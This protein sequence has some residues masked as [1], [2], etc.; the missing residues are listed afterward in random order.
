MKLHGDPL[1][2]K[3][4][5][6]VRFVFENWDG[7]A[8]WKRRNDKILQAR[9]FVRR[10][11]ADAYL[12]A[13]TRANWKALPYDSLLP[14]LFQ[15]QTELKAVAGHNIHEENGRAQEGGTCLMIFDFLTTVTSELGTDPTGLGRWCWAKFVG[16]N[17]HVT[18][19]VSAYQPV[20]AGKRQLKA[21]YQQHRR[22]FRSKGE[23]QCPRALFRRDL[24]ASVQEWKQAGERVIVMLDANEN[25][26]RGHLSRAF[27]SMGLRDLVHERTQTAGPATW[28]RGR[29]Q[30]DGVFATAGVECHG[31][32][33]LPFWAGIGDHRAI[34]VDIPLQS[35]IGEQLL[36]IVRPPARRLQCSQAQVRQRYVNVLR[37]QF[38]IHRIYEKTAALYQS[39]TYPPPPGFAK[40]AEALDRIRTQLMIHAEKVCRKRRMGEVD[41]SPEVIIWKKRRDV[42][43]EVI[44]YRSGGKINK[45]SLRR[46]AQ[47]CGINT[48]LSANLEAAKR[49]YKTCDQEFTRLKPYADSYRMAFLRERAEQSEAM[50]DTTYARDLRTMINKEKSRKMW[51]SIRSA[52]K[53][54]KG[55]SVTKVKVQVHGEWV[56]RESTEDVETGIM[57]ELTKRFRL[58]ESTPLMTGQLCTDLGFLAITDQA[59]AILNGTY[60]APEGTHPGTIAM[61]QRI[62]E[63]AATLRH[64]PVQVTISKEDFKKYW[65]GSKETTSSSYS[66]LHFGHSKAAASD[67]WL[68]ENHAMFIQ[69]ICQTGTHL[70][71]W[72]TGLTVMLEKIAGNFR[73]DKLRAILLMEA[74]F[75]FANKLLFGSRLMRQAE[76]HDVL[77]R[78]NYGSRHDHCSIEIALA[79][80]LFFDLVRQRKVSAAL[81]SVDAHTCYDRIVHCVL[82]FGQPS[83]GN[84]TGASIGDAFSHTA[85]DI[86]SSDSPWRF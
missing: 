5:G 75:N 69:L 48:P 62:S 59:D 51:R 32:R 16:K 19:L 3:P 1:G 80:L 44:K 31:A 18:R 74:D 71:R 49:A 58:T 81:A 25:L 47:A 86:P 8:P 55:G 33:F 6:V 35:L 10:V 52:I 7:C 21:V 14:Q 60:Q 39:A 36:K 57:L 76:D 72:S 13:E 73:V 9:R 84:A 12:G 70:T 43:R 67:D 79:R 64:R 45:T 41:Y 78:E 2:T 24:I 23:F 28:F 46:R 66:G 53:K 40:A 26:A 20:R 50:G 61:L 38:E 37:E 83:D 56:E 77:P 42:W 11:S 68:T 65:R 85:N 34:V 4:D 30:I 82:F 27:R 17:D 15:S 29:H 63:V 22:Y 54:H